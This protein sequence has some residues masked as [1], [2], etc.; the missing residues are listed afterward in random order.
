MADNSDVRTFA[1]KEPSVSDEKVP[2]LNDFTKF[3]P[4]Y[5]ALNAN[6]I[7][8][9]PALPTER[10]KRDENETDADREK[11]EKTKKETVDE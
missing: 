5:I 4:Q 8:C 2:E 1:E 11:K 3:P 6:P 9:V 10:E 7:V